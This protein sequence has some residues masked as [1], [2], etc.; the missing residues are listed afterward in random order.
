MKAPKSTKDSHYLLTIIEEVLSEEDKK[1][2][3]NSRNNAI[4]SQNIKDSIPSN[5][6]VYIQ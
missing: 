3:G 2:N 6:K 4:N 5:R 1:N